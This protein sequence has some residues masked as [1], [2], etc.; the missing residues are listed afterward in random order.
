M[1]KQG[2]LLIVDAVINPGNAFDINKY[3]DIQMLVFQGGKERTREQFR[4][5]L[6][7]AGFDL[8][9]IHPTATMFSIIEAIPA[10]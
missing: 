10:K 2:R 4:T 9:K 3:P 8:L 7:D 6:D 5:L 1:D